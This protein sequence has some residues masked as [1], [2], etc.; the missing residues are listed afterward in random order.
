M[1]WAVERPFRK[2]NWNWNK[3]SFFSIYPVSCLYIK[4]SNMCVMA[5]SVEIG[6]K[7]SG[8]VIS[9]PL[10]TGVGTIPWSKDWLKIF[11]SVSQIWSQASFIDFWGTPI[12][13]LLS[14]I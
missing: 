9:S 5:D 14:F 11:V 13:D 8:S 1:A 4:F 12:D 10:S 3:I 7:F 6:R 2:P